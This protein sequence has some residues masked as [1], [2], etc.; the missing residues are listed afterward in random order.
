MEP[1]ASPPTQIQKDRSFD[2]FGV[3][4]GF[5]IRAIW[6]SINLAVDRLDLDRVGV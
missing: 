4:D 2:G 6:C 5:V 3:R 1:F